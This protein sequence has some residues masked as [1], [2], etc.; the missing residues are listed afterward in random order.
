MHTLIDLERFPIDRPE[1]AEYAALVANCQADLAADG[2]YNLVG[3]LRPE[4]AQLAADHLK[5]EMAEN[6]YNHSRKHNIYFKKEL[7]D[8]PADHPALTEIQTRNHTLCADQLAGNAVTTLYQWQP[9]VTFLALTMGKEKLF[10]MD[11]T[12]AK[13]NV[14]AYRAGETLNWHFDRSEFTTTLLLQ[15]PKAGGDFEY[16]TDLRTADDPNYDGV[17]KLLRG[18]DLQL[19]SI[20]PTAG[21]LNVFRGI[22]TPHRVTKIEGDRDRMVAVYSFYDRPGV[23]FSAEEQM[24][25]YGRTTAAQN[26]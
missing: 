5:P 18:D 25:F 26:A 13:I 8:L 23:V 19:Q 20:T 1:S 7:S 2:M 9:L 15:A 11:D 17:A 4:Q 21:T 6:S 14:M 12:L 22:N 24:G 3:F 10:T 16:R